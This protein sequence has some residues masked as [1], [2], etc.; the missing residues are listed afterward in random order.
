[1]RR[2]NG[3]CLSCHYTASTQC[4][5]VQSTECVFALIIFNSKSIEMM[6]KGLFIVF[7]VDRS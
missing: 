7:L 4:V 1:M 3:V 6:R 5:R 2:I